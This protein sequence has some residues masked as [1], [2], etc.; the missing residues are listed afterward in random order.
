MNIQYIVIIQLAVA[1]FAIHKKSIQK[2][3][4]LARSRA[5]SLT[6]LPPPKYTKK[7]LTLKNIDSLTVLLAVT[8]HSTPLFRPI[9]IYHSTVVLSITNSDFTDQDYSRLCTA[10]TAELNE[11]GASGNFTLPA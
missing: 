5:L 7:C 6:K 3:K 8:P 10:Y 4:S 1:S 11:H 9:L 2:Y